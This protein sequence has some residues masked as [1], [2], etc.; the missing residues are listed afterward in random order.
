MEE[1][2]R[3]QQE[4]KN[5]RIEQIYIR[6]E[7]E[8]IRKKEMGPLLCIICGTKEKTSCQLHMK[9]HPDGNIIEE[10]VTQ[11]IKCNLCEFQ[12]ET[13]S[14]LGKHRKEQHFWGKA[15]SCK[16]CSKCYISSSALRQHRKLNHEKEKNRSLIPLY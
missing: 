8:F 10:K 1:R 4:N 13:H 16:S 7:N 12:T 15:Y 14:N 2:K 11:L 6:K 9:E 5:S 3:K